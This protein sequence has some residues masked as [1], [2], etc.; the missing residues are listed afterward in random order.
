MSVSHNPPINTSIP[1]AT[2]GLPVPVV[3]P[4]PP[5]ISPPELIPNPA[6]V[7]TTSAP[8]LTQNTTSIL[9]LF[10]QPPPTP[11]LM[12]FSV[13]VPASVYPDG[14][15]PTSI[16]YAG[17]LSNPLFG[18]FGATGP[19]GDIGPTGPGGQAANTGATG[20]PGPTGFTGP[21]GPG[22]QATNTGATGP[23]GP[24][25]NTG[26]AG[27]A[28]NTGAT[29]PQ[30]PTGI[31]GPTGV[32]GPTGLPSTV[33]GPTGIQGPTGVTGPTGLASTVTG[34]T[35]I[36]G[37]TGN[38]GPAGQAANTG[39]TGDTGPTGNTGPTGIQGPTGNTGPTGF[40]GPQGIPGPTGNTGPP[41]NASQWATF[42]AV[43]NVNMANYTINNAFNANIGNQLFA[44]S[45]KFGGSVLI[46]NA[47]ITS[48]GDLDCEDI[49]CDN[50]NVGTSTVGQADVNIYGANLVAGDNALYVEGGSTLSGAG[51]VHG[52]SIGA[53]TVGGINTQRI[54]VLPVGINLTA[55]TYISANAVGAA[56][57]SAGGALSF[58]GGDYIEYNSDEHRFINTSSGNQ[59]TT[60]SVGRVDGP[61]NVSNANPLIVGNSGSAGTQ[62]TNVT[63]LA[64]TNTVMTGITSIAGVSP[65][66]MAL[67]NVA[68]INGTVPFV[69]GQF[70]NTATVV[71]AG[72]NVPTIIP[73]TSTTAAN[74][75][76]IS[77]TGIRVNYSGIY[78]CTF[79]IQL[80][81]Q[82]G[83]LDI[84]WFWLRVNGND[85]PNS[86]SQITVQGQ[87][88][89]VL[90][91]LTSVLSLS[92]NDIVNVV[93]ASDDATMEAAYYPPYVNPPNPYNAPAVPS[94]IMT[95]KL[96]R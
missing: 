28:A 17:S 72:V 56:N 73:V 58:A 33:T 21:T 19:T 64:G 74:G 27:Q 29:G 41:S 40:T 96:L 52:V 84:A 24:T 95:L 11:S 88:G 89:E 80:D 75:M 48:G 39:A 2:I 44:N 57:M 22:G 68:S 1:P 46:P 83:G 16:L 91:N 18:G 25:G 4:P 23:P 76:S 31:Q 35:G 32:T 42:P 7:T 5:A 34:P 69:F 61:Y 59:A 9:S 85:V 15:P 70:L 81:K 67:T 63:S 12:T 26:P 8:I 78:E 14:L 92:A 47:T 53:L 43:A 93:L 51:V 66:G 37:P 90:A 10:S 60:I 36:Q 77:G 38:T 94:L 45:A 82:G 87:N 6:F 79:S 3:S 65:T 55:A 13:P 62:L 71:V 20:P 54:D 50:L 86:G 49:A 30:G